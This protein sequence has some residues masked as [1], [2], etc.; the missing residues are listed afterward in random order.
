MEESGPLIRPPPVD[1]IPHA[2]R[3]NE[4]PS[5]PPALSSPPC[6]SADRES[7]YLCEIARLSS[8][9]GELRCW[10][11]ASAAAAA[12][13]PLSLAAGTVTGSICMLLILC[14]VRV[15]LPSHEV[16]ARLVFSA[17]LACASWPLSFKLRDARRAKVA[18]DAGTDTP[19]AASKLE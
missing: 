6:S 12:L 2:P 9:F 4:E 18:A 19:K 15:L 3:K 1:T 10:E 5:S 11:G 17:L 7:V 16:A 8:Q 14:V 13:E